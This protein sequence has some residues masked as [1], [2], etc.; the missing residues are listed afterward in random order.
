MGFYMFYMFY[1]IV[2]CF[3]IFFYMFLYLFIYFSYVSLFFYMFLYVFIFFYMF[4]CFSIWSQ[5]DDNE[6]VLARRE[7]TKYKENI[8]LD[9]AI[10]MEAPSSQQ[11]AE[12]AWI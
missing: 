3:S 8:A 4:L 9:K 1:Y 12:F 2:L 7:K 5:P 10:G 11:Q 6:H